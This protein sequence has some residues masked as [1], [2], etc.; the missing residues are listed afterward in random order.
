MEQ[1]MHWQ[2]QSSGQPTRSPPNVTDI[3]GGALAPFEQ[4]V[5]ELQGKYV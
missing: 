1:D 5:R 2:M 3:F 4:L